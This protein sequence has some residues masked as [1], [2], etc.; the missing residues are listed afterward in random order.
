MDL[1]KFI[2]SL[3]VHIQNRISINEM[4]CWIFKGDPTPNGYQRCW[5]NG[6]RFMTHRLF[7]ELFYKKDIRKWQLD[8]LCEV[9]ACCNPEHMECVTP[10]ININRKFRRRKTIKTIIDEPFKP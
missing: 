10:K 5:Y 9:R 1:T 6:Q 3:P 2:N 8:H 4:H 7:Y